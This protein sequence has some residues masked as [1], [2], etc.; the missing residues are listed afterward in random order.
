MKE[1]EEIQSERMSFV[2]KFGIGQIIVAIIAAACLFAAERYS[3]IF[4]HILVELFSIVI[5]GGIFVIVWNSRKIVPNSYFLFLGITCIFA[6]F[7][8]LL[9]TLAYKGMPVFKG[10]G[11]D[12]PTQLWVVNRYVLAIGFLL[13]PLLIDRK[14]RT[15]ALF[16]I[17]GMASVIL[18]AMIFYWRIF[19]VCFVEGKGLTGFKTASE[20]VIAAMFAGGGFLLCAKAE[21]FDRYVLVLLVTAAILNILAELSFTVYVDPYGVANFVGHVFVVAAYYSIY[22]AIIETAL[23]RPYDLLFRDI[24]QYQNRLEEMV[25]AR[26]AE[27]ENANKQLEEE[28]LRLRSLAS[29]LSLSEE[30][31]RRE[32]AA[33]LHDH[34]G[35][36]LALAKMKLGAMRKMGTTPD[37]INTVYDFVEQSIEYTRTLTF[38]LSPPV[39]YN[40]G[41]AAAIE[42]LAEQFEKRVNIKTSVTDDGKDKPLANDIRV[43]LF[44]AVREL[45]H[46]IAKHAKATQVNISIEQDLDKIKVCVKDNGAGFEPSKISAAKGGFGLFNIRE[47]LEHIG[48]SL[49]IDSKIGQGS[50]IVIIA[51]LE[52]D[53]LEIGQA[54]QN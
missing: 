11:S 40:F 18:V 2:Q 16:V 53:N 33:G 50:Q 23:V 32:V 30:R 28:K 21:K 7:F 6:A 47:R 42:W 31:Q 20:Y 41:L 51:P 9:H 35:Q 27:L 25:Q 22:K 8:I 3:Y 39:L 44:Q 49:L 15:A 1:F 46:N 5:V 24:R 10:Y 19:P 26:T 38:E 12:L 48:G 17:F 54:E 34:L 43:V 4:F 36:L 29:E 13:A 37:D 52:A 14:L 45:L